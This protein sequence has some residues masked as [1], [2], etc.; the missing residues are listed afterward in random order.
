M[1][2]E[3]GWAAVTRTGVFGLPGQGGGSCNLP[4]TQHEYRAH[5]H[6]PGSEHTLRIASPDSPSHPTAPCP[7]PH[8]QIPAKQ[9]PTLTSPPHPPLPPRLNNPNPR[10]RLNR[11]HPDPVITI[12]V[13]TPTPLYLLLASP[14][15]TPTPTPTPIP[16]PLPL[17]LPPPFFIHAHR[18]RRRRRLTDLARIMFLLGLVQRCA[19]P[20]QRRIDK[21]ERSEVQEGRGKERERRTKTR[22]RQRAKRQDRT[23][24]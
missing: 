12:V 20:E 17:P 6:I 22:G 5:I 15:P 9:H 2:Y 14:A 24:R 11:P 13:T 8:A 10:P 18:R 4:V 7:N 1:Y 23:T 19:V 21:S 3:Y 16:L